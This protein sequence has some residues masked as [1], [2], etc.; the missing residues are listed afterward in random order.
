MVNSAGYAF[1]TCHV[2]TSTNRIQ[3]KSK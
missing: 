3:L 2:T 1:Q